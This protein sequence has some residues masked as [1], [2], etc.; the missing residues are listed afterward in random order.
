MIGKIAD[1]SNFPENLSLTNKY[2]SRLCQGFGYYS[3]AKISSSKT[4]ISRLM[5]LGQLPSSLIRFVKNLMDEKLNI[6]PFYRDL[7]K[8]PKKAVNSFR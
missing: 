6:N 4:P 1:K 7:Y 8:S 3:F 2:V 5:N